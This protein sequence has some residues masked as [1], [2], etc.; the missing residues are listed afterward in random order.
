MEFERFVPELKKSWE[1]NDSFK[2]EK[3][4]TDKTRTRTFFSLDLTITKLLARLPY[5]TAFTAEKQAKLEKK[6]QLKESK[7]NQDAEKDGVVSVEN[8]SAVSA[9]KPINERQ[10]KAAENQDEKMEEE[11]TAVDGNDSADNEN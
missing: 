6:K 10:E 9:E 4:F 2:P 1:G 8:N 3:L 11:E 7:E 5:V